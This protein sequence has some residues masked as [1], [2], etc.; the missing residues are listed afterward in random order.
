MESKTPIDVKMD[1][2]GGVVVEDMSLLATTEEAFRTQLEASLAFWKENGARSI[3][4]MFKP[5]KCHL[6]NI[7]AEKGFYFHHA[8]REENY[9]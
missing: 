1:K 7:A 2:Y 9:V 8:H 5:P 3:Q 6:M 4:I